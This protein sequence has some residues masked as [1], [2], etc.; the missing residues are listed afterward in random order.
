MALL[1]SKCSNWRV[2]NAIG[3]PGE[4]GSP[5]PSQTLP[6]DQSRICLAAHSRTGG[7]L[8]GLIIVS[9]ASGRG[10]PRIC[11]SR[12]K[13][14]EREHMKSWELQNTP[15]PETTLCRERRGNSE[16][17]REGS[18]MPARMIG[19][20]TE[21]FCLSKPFFQRIHPNRHSGHDDKD[22]WNGNRALYSS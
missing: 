2:A 15:R 12:C 22:P 1:G 11:P 10:S 13:P 6:T 20:F 9:G 19:T 16:Y 7:R 4:G 21:T 3:F 17:F 8:V 14:Y 5:P 18:C